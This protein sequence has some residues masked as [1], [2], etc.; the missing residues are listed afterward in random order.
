MYR[1]LIAEWN[2]S[3]R[4]SMPADPNDGLTL[5]ELIA[6]Y[7]RFCQ[8]YYTKN[9]EPTSEV[10]CVAESMRPL[11]ELYGRLPASEFGPLKLKT[12]RE[13]MIKKGWARTTVNGR[14]QRIRKMFKWA[15]ENEILTADKY[16]A[17]RAVAG[18][19]KGR[20]AAR[21]PRRVQPVAENHVEAILAHVSDQVA[22]MIRLQLLTGMRSGE[23]TIMRGIDLDMSGEVWNYRPAYHKTEHHEVERL[24]PLGP[25]AQQVIHPFLNRD[26]SAYLFSPSEAEAVRLK[27]RHAARTT[28]MSCG[29][30]PGSSRKRRRTRPARDR[31]D[32]NSYRRAI[33]RGCDVA[34]PAPEGMLAKDI[35][36]WQKDHRFH[37][38]QLRHT[39][40]TQI[41]R[42]YGLEAAKCIL[43]H[44]NIETTQIYAEVNQVQATRIM[45]EVG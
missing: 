39:A 33:C 11:R 43:G 5:V 44:S 21:E 24:I 19:R 45:A 15:V 6:R 13:E 12:V 40:A 27:N 38:H 29:N 10:P 9:G 36:A 2:A 32:T 4:R 22:A 1:R 31:Y 41:R 8:T 3:G 17:L 37:P 20:S 30:R 7:W 16:E 34:F 25:R 42:K 26:L 28:P 14:I 18:L 23:V 35:A